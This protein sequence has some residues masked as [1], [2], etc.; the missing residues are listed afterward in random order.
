M[1]DDSTFQRLPFEVQGVWWALL[2]YSMTE[3][4]VPGWFLDRA[5]G[6]PMSDNDIAYALAGSVE[7]IDTVKSALQALRKAGDGSHLA[8]HSRDGWCIPGYADRFC[9]T[10]ERRKVR[11]ADARRQR[12][13]RDRD[14]DAEHTVGPLNQGISG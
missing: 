11:E 1:L 8:H 6:A 5:T 13:R 4:K 9:T 7:R 12:R 2:L 10:G 3:S 14:R